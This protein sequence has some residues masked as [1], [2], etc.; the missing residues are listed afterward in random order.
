MSTINNPYIKPKYEKIAEL[1][2]EESALNKDYKRIEE[3]KKEIENLEV[4]SRAFAQDTIT[5]LK[6]NVYG[7]E[8]KRE[9]ATEKEKYPTIYKQY[10]A[11]CEVYRDAMQLVERIRNGKKM[12]REEISRKKR[13]SNE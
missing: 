7:T 10:K 5:T 12:I 9:E 11:I 3:L 6:S 8:Q 1:D 13:D 2:K 4:Q